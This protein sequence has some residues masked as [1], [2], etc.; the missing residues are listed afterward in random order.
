MVIGSGGWEAGTLENNYEDE[1][2]ER[3]LFDSLSFKC[4]QTC[5]TLRKADLPQL[6]GHCFGFGG[7]GQIFN[8]L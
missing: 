3:I 5:S 6:T 7:A 2:H 4:R 1:K 8:E